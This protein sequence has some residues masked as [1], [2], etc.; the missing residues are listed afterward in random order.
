MKAHLAVL[1]KYYLDLILEGKKTIEARFLKIKCPP[2]EKVSKGDKIILKE[3]GRPIRGEAIVKDVKYYN[4][5]TPQKILEIVHIYQDELMIKDDY[6]NL[7][8][9][10]NYLTLIFLGNI[11]KV[12]MPLPIVKKDRRGWVVL[13]D[14]NQLSLFKFNLDGEII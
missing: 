5:L 6:L 9:N 2:Y 8:I 14:D 1:Y 11:K 10:S 13:S 12:E 3:T 7:K 4:N